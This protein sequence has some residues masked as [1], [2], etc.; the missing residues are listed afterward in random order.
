MN[1]LLDPPLGQLHG[2][3]RALSVRRNLIMDRSFV[4]TTLHRASLLILLTFRC[5]I[6]RGLI[7]FKIWIDTMLL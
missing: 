4:S 6:P 1:E 2:I 7:H 3:L 5:K